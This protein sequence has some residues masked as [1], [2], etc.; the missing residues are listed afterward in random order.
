M[1]RTFNIN[2]MANSAKKW[3]LLLFF[4]NMTPY[5]FAATDPVIVT[6][7]QGSN[8]EIVPGAERETV[9][10]NYYSSHINDI[11]N[12]AN[13]IYTN[14]IALVVDEDNTRFIAADFIATVV[15]DIYWTDKAGN[16]Q[17]PVRKT[18][19][20]NYKIAEG[21]KYDARNY[22]Y[23]D[24]ARKVKVVVYSV[25]KHGAAW[26]ITEILTL[27]NRMEVKRD[28]KFTCST[29]ATGVQAAPGAASP[30]NK[31]DELIVSWTDQP[32]K[33]ITHYDVEWAWVDIDALD[34]YK[35][36]SPLSF[37]AEL[38]F[39]NNSSRVTISAAASFY[40]VPLI[41]DGSGYLF[42]RVRPVQYRENE[43]V[44]EGSWS[45]SAN[46]GITYYSYTTGHEPD[47]NWQVST[48]YAEDGKR[49]T[50][51]SYFD[52]TLRSRQTVT[53]DNVNNNTVVAE[54]LYD[55]QGRPA[56]SILPAP[57]LNTVIAYAKN[58]NRFAA[59]GNPKD[60]YDL[61]PAGQTICA[62]NTPA[63]DNNYGASNYYSPAN[64]RVNEGINKYIPDA[65]GYPYAETR[66]TPD[67]TG[68]IASQSGVGPDY[69]LGDGKHAT[70]YYYG[71][72]DQHELNA[73]FGTEAG[74]QSHYFKNMVKDANGQFSVS[75]TDM[76]GR[77]VATALAGTPPASLQNMASYQPQTMTRS[78][79]GRKNN[80][81][82]DRSIEM[83]TTLL[84][85]KAGPH[86]F[87][88]QLSP[89]SA[90]IVACNPA[91][92]TICYDCYYDLEIRIANTC[93]SQA[94]I[95]ITRRNFTFGNYDINCTT[96]S[97]ALTVDETYTL[98]EGEYNISKKLTLSKDAQDWYRENVFAP[99]NI[100]KTLQQFIDENYQ[101]MMAAGNCGLTCTT[102]SAALGSYA[103]FRTK[104][105]QLI[106]IDPASTNLP[107]E[108]EILASYNE[109][110]ENCN[111]LCEEPESKL[112]IIREIM[113]QDV[114]P[115]QGQ[116]AKL[117]SDLNGNGEIEPGVFIYPTGDAASGIKEWEINT[118][119]PY[120]IFNNSAPYRGYRPVQ[121]AYFRY[122]KDEK[123]N[124]AFYKTEFGLQDQPTNPALAVITP[125]DF[126]D[127]FGTN[128]PASLIYYHPEYYKLKIAE[129]Y[130][131]GS[132]KWDGKLETA[133]T[134]QAA[135]TAGYMNVQTML[136][137]DPFFSGPGNS[138]RVTM[139][140]YMQE[141]FKDGNS[142]WKLALRTV[143]CLN[144]NDPACG[145]GLA[146][147]PPY[148]T[149]ACTG[150]WNYVWRIFRTLYLTEKDKMVNLYLDQQAGTI[151]YNQLKELGYERRFG[152]YDNYYKDYLNHLA[153]IIAEAENPET[154]L[155][156][157]TNAQLLE[158][159][160]LTCD[161][162]IDLWKSKLLACDQLANHPQKEAIL[163]AITNQ[164]KQVCIWG[165]DADHVY[166]SSTLPPGDPRTPNSFET[167]I[168]NVFAT[169][170]ISRSSLCH[171]F[172]AD[173]PQAYN[174]QP[175]A[176]DVVVTEPADECVCS[177]LIEL[178]NE[179][180]AAGHAGSLSE[181]I[182]YHHG[183]YIRQTLL[184]SLSAGCVSSCK[185]YDPPVIIPPILSCKTYIS[186][187]I[188]CDEYASLKTDFIKDYGGTSLY[189][190]PQ[191]EEEINKNIYFAQF[192]NAQR[193]FRKTWGDYLQFEL[194]CE[195]YNQ[196]WTCTRLDSIIAAFHLAY[197]NA[198]YGTGCQQAFTN[199]FNQAFGTSYTFP[200][201]EALYQQYCGQP[202]L[203]CQPT[204]DC[205]QFNQLIKDF[206]QLYGNTIANSTNCQG[207]FTA[208]FNT[209]FGTNHTWATLQALFLTVC[210]RELDVC[211]PFSSV[212]LQLAMADWRNQQPLAW[213]G[214]NCL[215]LW[216]SFFNTWFQVNLAEW[217]IAELYQDYKGPYNKPCLPPVQC[218][219]L[220]QVINSYN[221]RGEAACN[222][223]GYSNNSP[224]FCNDCFT[225]FVNQQLNT[226]YTY[227]QISLMYQVGCGSNLGVCGNIYNCGDLSD[228][229]SNFI[230]S[231]QGG[232]AGCPDSFVLYF[233]NQYNTT[234]N[235]TEI[236]TLYQLYC[237]TQPSL[238]GKIQITT[239]TQL[240]NVKNDFLSL[241]PN[242][243]S[244]FGFRC[245]TAF[246]SYFNQVFGDTLSYPA[247]DLYYINLCGAALDI[248][249]N[250]GC[251]GLGDF[252]A[253]YHAQYDTLA[254]PQAL[255]HDLF[256]KLFNQY[257]Q[258]NG[259][260]GDK[261]EAIFYTWPEVAA[262]Y[263]HCGIN[264]NICY[265]DVGLLTSCDK[266][267][268][269]KQVFYLFYS[270]ANAPGTCDQLFTEFFNLYFNTAFTDYSSLEQWVYSQCGTPLLHVC[271]SGTG[272]GGG[273]E[274]GAGEPPPNI[275]DVPLPTAPMLCETGSLFP[276]LLEEPKD[277]CD[278]IK[279]MALN[280]GTEQYTNYIKR[281]K[282]DFDKRYTEK[283]LGAAN[284]EV[285]T[286]TSQVAEYHYTLYYYDQAG[287]LVKTIPPAG[288]N[289]N[290]SAG[291][292]NQVEAARENVENGQSPTANIVVPAHTLATEYRYNTLG[293][294]IAQKS[295]D[296]GL[297]KF[298]YDRL[299]RLV[300]SQN[301]KQAAIP[302]SGGGGA[303]SYTKYDELGRITEV[304]QLTGA[305][306]TQTLT[307]SITQL[308]T[309]F[310]NAN[311]SR[312]Q[313]TVTQ[314]DLPK[315]ELCVPAPSVLCQANLRNRVSYTY[316]QP[317]AAY[318]NNGL[319]YTAATYYT[320]DIHGN[321]DVLLQHYNSGI[322]Q[323]V[324]GNAFKRI[325]YKYDLV[326]GK[327]NEVA[328]QPGV[329]DQ[330]YHRYAYDAENKLTKVETS[331]DYVYW[332]QQGAY[333]YY[334]H[335]PLARTEIGQL[336]VQGT[337]YVYTLQGWLKG[338]NTTSPNPSTG[339]GGL[340]PGGDGVSGVRTARDAYGFSLNYNTADYTAIN[341][342]V[343]PYAAV[344]N[345]LPQLGADGVN[346]GRNL[347][348]GN[349][350]AMLVNIPKL[351]EAKLY[352]YQY[353]QLNR[354]TAMNA[355]NGLNTTTN[356][357]TPVVLDDYKE[358][359]SYDANGNILTYIRNGTTQGGT[360]QTMDNLTYYYKAAKNQLDY[361]ND[362]VPAGYYST[363]IDAQTAGN[364]EYDEIGNLTKDV[365]EG[366]SINGISWTVYGK[367]ASIT[368]TN[369]T[370]INYTYD[371]SGNR[372]SKQVIPPSGGGGATTFYVRDASGNVMAVYENG[373]SAIN[374]GKLSQ[375]EVDLYGS[376]R[377]GIWQR[378]LD[379]ES[380]NWWLFDKTA[381]AGTSG[382]TMAVLTRGGIGYELSNHLGNVLVSVSDRKL[383]VD[384]DNNGLIDYYT[385]DVVSATDN[386][387]FGMT[388]PG[389]S[390]QS[391]KYRYGFNGKEKDKD[392]SEGGQDYGMRISDNRLGRF[393]SV[394]PI[395][396]KYPELTPYQF[397]SN[398]PIQA[399]DLDG[400]EADFS[401]GKMPKQ[402]Y[403]PGIPK[404][405]QI[406]T[407]QHNVT[408]AT[409]NS[410]IQTAEDGVN[411][412]NDKGRKQVFLK[413][414]QAADS[415][416]KFS[417][418]PIDHQ[419]AIIKNYFSNVDNIE[420]FLGGLIAGEI[421]TVG[422]SNLPALFKTMGSI[423]RRIFN[424]FKGA[425]PFE[426]LGQLR[427][428]AITPGIGETNLLDYSTKWFGSRKVSKFSNVLIGKVDEAATKYLWTIDNRGIN[429]ALE[430]TPAATERTFITHTNISDFAYAGGEVW[431][432]SKNS[433]YINAKSARF[434]GASMSL[435]QYNAAKAAWEKLGYRVE[436]ADFIIPK[437]T[438]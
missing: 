1:I 34:R 56:L 44:V 87:H 229:A 23:F 381:M 306:V 412:F 430:Q 48:T 337:D 157:E 268:A 120:N 372:I 43:Q 209:H 96:P 104:F 370:V 97:P 397:A 250:T 51:I 80:V 25:D 183:L 327:V 395:T 200:A 148:A 383:Q 266:M 31:I 77:T 78:L 289:P 10:L 286:V 256:T 314:Y 212:R 86:T 426:G 373:N 305:T 60:I 130:L 432:T 288:V 421:V 429:I 353:D 8:H 236:M 422:I 400:L 118:N 336:G 65:E 300:V 404:L 71:T 170:N 151:N 287:S 165:S 180:I 102:C 267:R 174:K 30:D 179:K 241:Y 81:V 394:D 189:R 295:P 89:Q 420:N 18:L 110:K 367:I 187:C 386:Y 358:R 203:V 194:A 259:S 239:C 342:S 211:N 7:M 105:L 27:E 182:Q 131:P 21:T 245:Q 163:T 399:S 227:E 177:R 263:Q 237:G 360:Q 201:L 14:S 218:E 42:Y 72:A 139:L 46:T 224:A 255:C 438:K 99:H 347:Y 36:G 106:N 271:N 247:I 270:A 368:K 319:P 223:S 392:I 5:A 382:G 261:G 221:N 149:N 117:N 302:L 197:P 186:N 58:F 285:F 94:P 154:T 339:G 303:Y 75:Y 109:A 84:V 296:G 350:R 73:L 40:K 116:Y 24:N 126:S 152:H 291:F 202:L 324:T 354:I 369:G 26:D 98:E 29:A 35:S 416:N 278:Y 248:C 390:Y 385:A 328:Y 129:Q 13:D 28:Y 425:S 108:N 317:T 175:V 344:G 196:T 377:L 279:T 67:A 419:F 253:I 376:S 276:T 159:Y 37:D 195:S 181:F 79:L 112:S 299:G 166:G 82:K 88:Y 240:D 405:F 380:T 95:V 190:Q 160:T 135:Q 63:L 76:H 167:I 156:N 219:T 124:T 192:M 355:Y 38:L 398:T 232:N 345:G 15:V 264:L 410:I 341:S 50:V 144:S 140:K 64:S 348:N 62:M 402:E 323:T 249:S 269:A 161:S 205:I 143:N 340:D 333:S 407:F 294:V 12:P 214:G 17:G 162:Y 74:E 119:R 434:G 188:S 384:S 277:P 252:L 20:V 297:S 281:Q 320:Y 9:D 3:L 146:Q 191:N 406:E 115:H 204:I 316:V 433:V 362:G 47:L 282:N 396:A 69:Q 349:I 311:A 332:Q 389:R 233:N 107:Y 409:V 274:A 238:C 132:Y 164:M 93:S 54:T 415:W 4:S 272:E 365:N 293:Q 226:N 307:Q 260:G 198:G 216:T 147:T 121:P 111:A 217:Q 70:N 142:M 371:A 378:N 304:G 329:K 423:P 113:L 326:S 321:V 158:Q 414:A 210:G 312:E 150:D 55:Y 357:F 176:G 206:Y 215:Q 228:L 145:A 68:R 427:A 16:A 330:Y 173:F 251:Q 379:V 11:D 41:Y 374:A 153:A 133:D 6:R 431:F 59:G 310:T 283:C 352:G 309:W 193:G 290:F 83:A 91:G 61:V 125:D 403:I 136:N 292:Y 417:Q 114:T 257:Q 231:Y 424:A 155:V 2:S 325:E 185:T 242:A 375:I 391:D 122:P 244:Y 127:Q 49:K 178:K 90:E 308:D 66:Y 265:G 388:M 313:I 33:G 401:K 437:K 408:A 220:Q 134:W 171:S 359:V 428:P 387:V 351:G 128:W 19:E 225:W 298:W 280:K 230:S 45:A 393:L 318:S 92:Q 338:V 335:G 363:D 346:T 199:Y 138:Y 52:G 254:M 315:T 85:P 411:V 366:I 168:T 39:R 322:M 22:F 235:Y 262:M 418:L 213:A 57:T 436:A 53:R 258:V 284:L 103:Q 184:D 361:V 141:D 101:L 100:C 331:A 234:L 246:A 275:P 243:G 435:D 334:R 343:L 137:L 208:Y 169:Y 364:Y 356:V 413:V 301:A 32:F 273:E 207:L 123:D 222:G 172:L